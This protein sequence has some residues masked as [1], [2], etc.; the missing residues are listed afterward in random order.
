MSLST[1]SDE[2]DA[3]DAIWQR[4]RFYACPYYVHKSRNQGLGRGFLFLQSNSTLAE[5]SLPK[6]LSSDGRAMEDRLVLLH[7]LTVG[8]YDS[9]LCRDDFELA[10][11]RDELKGCVEGHVG[12]KEVVVLMRLRCGHLAVGRMVLVPDLGIS[13]ALGKDYYGDVNDQK[14]L[15]LNL[16]DL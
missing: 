10:V 12:E 3:R 14:A 15:Q 2:S 5:L 9:E 1:A 11:V 8:E 6:P 4:V 16:D 7:F 13:L